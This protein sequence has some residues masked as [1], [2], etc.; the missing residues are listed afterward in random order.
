MPFVALDFALSIVGTNQIESVGKSLNITYR[1][2][3]QDRWLREAPV[4]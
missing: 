2:V 3:T 1:Q 4:L